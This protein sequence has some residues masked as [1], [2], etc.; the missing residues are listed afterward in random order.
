MS[1]DFKFWSYIKQDLL[2]KNHLQYGEGF[3]PNSKLS[4]WLGILSPRYWPVFLSRVSYFFYISRLPFLSKMF[5]FFNQFFFGIE[6]SMRC[7]IGPGLYLPHPLG[8]V[9][10]ASSIGANAIIFQGVTL[11]AKELDVFY[12]AELRPVLGDNIVVGAGAKV[13]GGIYLAD[14]TVV[15]AN[16][17]LIQSTEPY[18]IYVGLP[19]KKCDKS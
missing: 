12:N 4:L 6:I 14:S 9:I 19:A 5:S 3:I 10:G 16:A 11:G 1:F 15:G 8:V 17:V 13:L 18:G 2:R 7:H